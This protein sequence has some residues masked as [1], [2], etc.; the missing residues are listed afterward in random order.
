ML[1]LLLARTLQN[2]QQK[3]DIDNDDDDSSAKAEDATQLLVYVHC[4]D[5]SER[6]SASV[7]FKC[8]TEKSSVAS[9]QLRSDQTIGI[10]SPQ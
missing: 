9:E 5:V 1:L 4:I 10:I 2:G 7:A 8:D 6:A 3:D